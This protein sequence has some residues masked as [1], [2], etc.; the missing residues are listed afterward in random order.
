MTVHRRPRTAL[1]TTK[2]PSYLLGSGL[3][4]AGCA[5]PACGDTRADELR[6]H[7]DSMQ[8]A[9]SR[10]DVASV[11]REFAIATGLRAHPPT[12]V[13]GVRNV[14]IDTEQ[15]TGGV[16]APVDPVPPPPPPV[17]AHEPPQTRMG[18]IA[19]HHVEPPVPQPPRHRH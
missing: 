11:A 6:A 14:Q 5:D 17:E 19:V 8:Q 16:P 7:A 3:V 2:I 10:G 15:V 1:T 13:E 18:R 12:R 9:S 4:A